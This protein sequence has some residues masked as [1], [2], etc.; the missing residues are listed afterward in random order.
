M[1]REHD[2]EG[3]RRKV[4]KRA[5]PAALLDAIYK[6]EGWT[7]ACGEVRVRRANI[8]YVITRDNRAGVYVAIRKLEA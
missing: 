2:L 1:A 7:R 8:L 3:K 6:A 4:I 5:I